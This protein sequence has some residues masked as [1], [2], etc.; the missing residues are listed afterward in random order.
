[1]S[2][3]IIYMRESMS[4]PVEFDRY[5]KMAV[6]T[7]KNHPGRALA[8]YGK[9]EILEGAA[10]EGAVILEF[11]SIEEAHRWF[12]SPEYQAAVVHR[13]AAAAYRVFIIEGASQSSRFSHS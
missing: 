3:Y 11:P 9:L 8:F 6:P 10:F 4:D 7:L 13:K 5:T 1:V 12:D 2:A